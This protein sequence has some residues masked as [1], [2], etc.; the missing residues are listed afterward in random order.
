MERLEKL[1]SVH[2]LFRQLAVADIGVVSVF[3]LTQ[4][5][6]TLLCWNPKELKAVPL[7]PHFGCVKSLVAQIIA[8]F[9]LISF[10]WRVEDWT[11]VHG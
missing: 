9:R 11:R 4:V 10:E 2:L 3:I 8:F 5:G 7:C 1:S 6:Q